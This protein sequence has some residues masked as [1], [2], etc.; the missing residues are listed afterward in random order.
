MYLLWDYEQENENEKAA[1]LIIW[2]LNRKFL[3]MSFQIGIN[4]TS[5]RV[6]GSIIIILPKI[7]T[8]HV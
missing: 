1:I 2:I 8:K 4:C 6:F 3:L 5:Q 7:I